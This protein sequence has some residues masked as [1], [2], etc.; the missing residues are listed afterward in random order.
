MPALNV[1]RK[2]QAIREHAYHLWE[3]DGRPHGRDVEFWE[4]AAQE[5]ASL[6]RR[7]GAGVAAASAAK[8]K[9]PVSKP[10]KAATP[11]VRTS[12]PK[13]KAERTPKA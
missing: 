13:L 7:R 10:A 1:Q 8:T 5:I 12:A 9:A 11:R 3:Q 2:E 4:R 6:T